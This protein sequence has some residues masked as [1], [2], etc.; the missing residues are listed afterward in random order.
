M[1]TT[2]PRQRSTPSSDELLDA[3]YTLTATALCGHI[4]WP[5]G[6]RGHDHAAAAIRQA[7]QVLRRSNRFRDDATAREVLR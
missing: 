1:T 2:P 3:L 7:K 4:Q 6:T 5:E